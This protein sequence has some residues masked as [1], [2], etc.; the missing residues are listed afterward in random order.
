MLNDT[1]HPL[2]PDRT[3]ADKLYEQYAKPLEKDHWGEYIAISPD[4]KMMLGR[5]TTQ[6]LKNSA[7]AF[8]PG[9]Y[10][11]KIGPRAVGRWI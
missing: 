4:G 9:N 6:L 7:Q 2:K 11:F 3:L 5:D 8:G 10:I 1:Q